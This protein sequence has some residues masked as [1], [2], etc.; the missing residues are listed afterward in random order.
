MNVVIMNI[1]GDVRLLSH[2]V[3]RIIP[4]GKWLK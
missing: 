3:T 2:D 4:D 1:T